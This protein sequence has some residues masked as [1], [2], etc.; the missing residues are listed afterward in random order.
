VKRRVGDDG[1][2]LRS[3]QPPE[4]E[5]VDQI[6]QSTGVQGDDGSRRTE[7]DLGGPTAQ[8][9]REDRQRLLDELIVGSE[10]GRSGKR[11][12]RSLQVPRCPRWIEQGKEPLGSRQAPVIRRL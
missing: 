9:D 2:P 3:C 11:G 7:P 12:Q 5:L 6:G 1:E 4:E 10:A 8:W